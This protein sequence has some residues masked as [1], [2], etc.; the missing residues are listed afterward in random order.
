MTRVPVVP[1]LL[2]A[3]LAGPALPAEP[4]QPATVRAPDGKPPPSGEVEAELL[5]FLGSVDDE[6][7]G[8]S[9]LEYLLRTDIARLA[10]NRNRARS[11]GEK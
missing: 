1:G 9:W 11:Q 5:E 10:R 8:E 2:T 6:A 7:T 4:V 3:L